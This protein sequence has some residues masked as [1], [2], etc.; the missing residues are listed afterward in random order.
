MAKKKDK[1]TEPAQ[2]HWSA[3]DIRKPWCDMDWKQAYVPGASEAVSIDLPM[4]ES[5]MHNLPVFLTDVEMG[6]YSKQQ[7]DLWMKWGRLNQEKKD[8]AAV[9]KKLIENVEGELDEIS[10]IIEEDSEERPVE[11][12]WM[13]DYEHNCKKMVRIDRNIVVEETTLTKE[14]LERWRCPELFENSPVNTEHPAEATDPLPE[15]G[16]VLDGGKSEDVGSKPDSANTG[17]CV[18]TPEDTPCTGCDKCQIP[19][20]PESEDGWA[21]PPPAQKPLEID[22]KRNCCMPKD[23]AFCVDGAIRTLYCTVCRLIINIEDTST[24]PFTAIPFTHGEKMAE[25][26]A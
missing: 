22:K 25:I 19:D 8:N 11:C 3:G 26:P 4:S 10:R 15:V 9:F 14:E 13:Y 21:D 23:R 24:K 17:L 18:L 16:E 7:A 20:E 2:Q 1:Q 12:C 5:F 6:C